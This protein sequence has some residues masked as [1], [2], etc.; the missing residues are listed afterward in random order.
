MRAALTDQRLARRGQLTAFSRLTPSYPKSPERLSILT[1]PKQQ[2]KHV[3]DESM[4]PL[5]HVAD[6]PPQ[7]PMRAEHVADARRR[8][9]A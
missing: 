9:A 8:A 7:P 2:M 5:Q 4:L 3:E 1:R 6:A